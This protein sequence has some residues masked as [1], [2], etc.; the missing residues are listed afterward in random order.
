MRRDSHHELESLYGHHPRR[1]GPVLNPTRRETDHEKGLSALGLQRMRPM[2][3]LEQQFGGQSFPNGYQL[4]DGVAMHTENPEHFHIPPDVMKRNIQVGFYVELRIDSDRF[5][6]HDGAAEVCSCPSCNGEITKPI[7]RHLHPASILAIP[8]QSV[9]SRGWGE[10][11]WV[12]IEERGGSYFKGAIDNPLVESRLHELKLQDEVVFHERHILAMH[13]IHRRDLLIGMG[14][15]DLKELASWL[16][17]Q[18]R[19]EE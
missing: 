15:E 3:D 1:K 14:S 4:V 19:S 5:S 6:V 11:F 16:G 10:D 2:T 7:Y 17:Q 12:R 8:P 9:P 13:D 18:N